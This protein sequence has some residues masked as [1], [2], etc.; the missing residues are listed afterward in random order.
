MLFCGKAAK[1]K[2]KLAGVTKESITDGRGLRYTVF[3]QGC[4]HHCK[5][6]HNPETWDFDAGYDT[7]TDEIIEDFKKNPL[8]KGITLSGGEPISQ[9]EACFDLAKNAHA[10]GKDVTLFTGWTL[11]ELTGMQNPTVNAL[12]DEIDVLV[13]G[14]FIEEKKNLELLFRGSENQRLIDMRRT[15]ERG[16]IVTIIRR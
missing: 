5:G 1:M 6:C 2:I 14:K 13:D 12:L 4:P 10:A 16:E 9:A 7:D 15:R 8:L 3:T 11:E